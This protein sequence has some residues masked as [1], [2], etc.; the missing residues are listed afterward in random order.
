MIFRIATRTD[1]PAIL[2]L[3]A[4]DEVSRSRDGTIPEH[5]DR[6]LIVVPPV[7]DQDAS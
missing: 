5:E 2:E 4:D 3:L 6:P 1:L 7:G